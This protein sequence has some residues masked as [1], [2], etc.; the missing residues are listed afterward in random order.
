MRLIASHVTGLSV[1]QV[2]ARPET[3]LSPDQLAALKDL[4]AKRGNAMPMAHILG[5]REFW[6]MDLR[7]SADTLVP[8]PDSETLIELVIDLYR[9][10]SHPSRVLDLGT[11][12]GCLAFA[13]LQEFPNATALATDIS[14]P[15]LRVAKNNADSLALSE[16]IDFRAT[17]WCD[18]ISG[19]FDLIVS[20]PPYIPSDDVDE[21]DA[22]VRD[23]E[24]RLALDGG[25]DGL[26]AYR[27]ILLGIRGLL[28]SDGWVVFEIGLGQLEQLEPLAASEGYECVASLGDAANVTR[29]VAFR[30]K[31]V[32]FVNGSR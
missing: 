6:S 28:P 30:K 22:T 9:H 10:R 11:G 25:D 21:L 24:P 15:A 14:L 1:A 20:N 32:G 3:N 5:R 12:T 16:R 2:Y 26:D 23:Y 8:R 31:S 19:E 18:G 4:T 13:L 17:S 27:A 7:V 29:A